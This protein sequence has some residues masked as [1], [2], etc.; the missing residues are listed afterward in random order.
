MYQVALFLA[1]FKVLMSLIQSLY[2][3]KNFQNRFLFNLGIKHYNFN[4]DIRKVIMMSKYVIT[5]T[6]N[7]NVIICTKNHQEVVLIGK[8]IGF[9]KKVGM[10]VQEN[11]SIEKFY[12]LEQQEQQEHYKTLLE[13]GEDHVVQ[14][15][16]DSVN[17]INESGLITDD[18][19]LVVALTDHIIYAY[20]RLKQHQMITNPFVIETKHLYSNAYNV[21]RKV[22]DKLNKTLDVHFPEDEIGFIALHIASNSEKLSI[23]DI[24][25]INKLINKSITIIET[26]LQHS[27]DKQTIQYQRF[28]RH[29]QF[30]IYRLTKGEY[31]EAQENFISMIKTM[32]PRS[33]NT[34]YKI[35]KM[36]QRE[37]SVYVYEAEIVYLT[38]HINHFE[39]QISSK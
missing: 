19:N 31:L 17:I 11:A 38:L 29:I 14:A 36:I 6:L 24:S 23:H 21:A 39:V 1:R 13:L 10:T 5:K 16:I 8:G 32:Y 4:N 37:F 30:L 33:F 3:S 12:K 26:D 15:V 34:A 27:I 28:I 9:N 35:L 22:I 7:N 18:K 20:K 2:N 25:I